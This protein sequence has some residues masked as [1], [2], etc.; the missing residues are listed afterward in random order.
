MVLNGSHAK[1]IKVTRM[2]STHKPAQII[3]HSLYARHVRDSSDEELYNQSRRNV[4]NAGF[5]SGDED[6]FGGEDESNYQYEA[7]DGAGY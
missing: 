4:I 1:N 3:F 7:R 2:A 5:S 6:H